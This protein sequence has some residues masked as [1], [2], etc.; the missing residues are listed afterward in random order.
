MP[1]VIDDVPVRIKR[2][3]ADHFCAI[4]DH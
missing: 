1:A 2:T 3:F 4:S